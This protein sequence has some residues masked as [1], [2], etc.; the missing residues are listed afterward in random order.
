MSFVSKDLALCCG[1]ATPV[2]GIFRSGTHEDRQSRLSNPAARP[3]DAPPLDQSRYPLH[4]LL[5]LG[6][7]PSRGRQA[8]L[9]LQVDQ[10]AA[11]VPRGDRARREMRRDLDKFILR[12]TVLLAL[13][14]L[15]LHERVRRGT[16]RARQEDTLGFEE[17]TYCL[18]AVL[19]SQ[20]GFFHTAERHHETVGAIGVH[21]HCSCL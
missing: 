1:N 13:R 17:L 16:C 14:R 18:D 19:P 3:A 21:P 12:H 20:P 8:P 15:T 4:R 6:L 7:K 10:L 5:M 2:D 9:L 11:L